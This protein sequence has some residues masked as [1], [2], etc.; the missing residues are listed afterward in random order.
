MLQRALGALAALIFAIGS[1]TALAQYPTKPV[2]VVLRR[3][4][5]KVSNGSDP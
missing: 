1:T 3:G 4:S 2:R 5:Q